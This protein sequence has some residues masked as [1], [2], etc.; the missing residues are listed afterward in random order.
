MIELHPTGVSVEVQSDVE[1]LLGFAES[2]GFE[3]II[4]TTDAAL[5]QVVAAELFER[6]GSIPF[7]RVIRFADGDELISEVRSWQGIG[8]DPHLASRLRGAAPPFRVVERNL[9][10]RLRRT[11]GAR[12]PPEDVG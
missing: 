9:A 10:H 2:A 3:R 12:I 8:I 5:E 4:A 1:G 11:D 6:M 7:M